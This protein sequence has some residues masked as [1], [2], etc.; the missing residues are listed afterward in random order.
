LFRGASRTASVSAIVPHVQVFRRNGVEPVEVRF[1]HRGVIIRRVAILVHF[2]VEFLIYHQLRVRFPFLLESYQQ[3]LVEQPE[4]VFVL[5]VLKGGSLAEPDLILANELAFS[6][7]SQR[8]L[9]AGALRN[10]LVLDFAEAM[11][12]IQVELERSLR[13][14]ELERDDAGVLDQE[15]YS[16]LCEVQVRV[17][18]GPF[19]QASHQ[20]LLF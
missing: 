9:P 14:V 8:K 13:K 19:Y 20:R 5:E 15:R 18:R 12:R 3:V 6:R 7:R 10:Q 2:V 16:G 11:A 1:D 4:K 17:R